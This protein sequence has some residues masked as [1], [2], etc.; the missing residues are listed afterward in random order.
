MTDFTPPSYLS[1]TV[2]HDPGD[3][4]CGCKDCRLELERE[5][6]RISHWEQEQ[7]RWYSTP[8]LQQPWD[9]DPD[10]SNHNSE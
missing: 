3:F 4:C 6:Q 7:A 10:L 5:R 9:P 1:F 2:K 8:K